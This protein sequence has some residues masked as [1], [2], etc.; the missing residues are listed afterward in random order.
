MPDQHPYLQTAIKQPTLH[1]RRLFADPAVMDR[2]G[3]GRQ[4]LKIREVT[5]LERDYG[6]VAGI[7]V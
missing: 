5:H 1:R 2:P 4:Q 7:G 6:D 3:L